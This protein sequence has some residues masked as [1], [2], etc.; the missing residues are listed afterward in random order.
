MK[1]HLNKPTQNQPRVLIV[2]DEKNIRT[3]LSL[4]LEQM[5]CEVGEAASAENAL[6]ALT[7]QP[8]DLA[9]L[10]LRLGEASG[11][12]LIPQLLAEDPNLSIIVITAYA[13]I[14]TAVEAIKRGANDYIPKPFTPAQIE[15]VIKKAAERREHGPCGSPPAL[16][17]GNDAR[18]RPAGALLSASRGF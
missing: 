16:K 9:F 3:T 17:A 13:T 18:S 7:R 14:D 12:D 1:P 2:D 15:H 10:D 4:C 5:G 11:L 8:Y 6:T